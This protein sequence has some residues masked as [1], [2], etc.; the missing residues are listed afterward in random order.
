MKANAESVLRF[1]V[2]SV[3]IRRRVSRKRRDLVLSGPGL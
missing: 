1:N 3:E 2:F